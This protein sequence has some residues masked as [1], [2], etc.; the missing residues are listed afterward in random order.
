MKR[1][2][3]KLQ[4]V[5][6]GLSLLTCPLMTAGANASAPPDRFSNAELDELLAPIAL[7]PDPLLA[8][9]L[10]AATFADQIPAAAQWADQHHYLTDGALM[11]TIAADRVPWDPSVQALLPFPSVL[12]MMALH[13]HPVL[14]SFDRLCS[15][16]AWNR[17]RDVEKNSAKG[18]KGDS[19]KC[20]VIGTSTGCSGRIAC[21]CGNL[22]DPRTIG[23]LLRRRVR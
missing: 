5:V 1:I 8:Q 7:Y 15:A 9:I 22:C 23:R 19:H 20:P 12:D 13:H 4:A 18:A 17:S 14:R 2:V 21:D 6:L 3:F 16:P 10:A 11:A